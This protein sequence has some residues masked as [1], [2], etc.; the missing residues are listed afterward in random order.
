[1]HVVTP[2]C[3]AQIAYE[4]SR[5]E[6][7]NV[8]YQTAPDAEQ[9][10]DPPVP[11]WSR[12]RAAATTARSA[13]SRRPLSGGPSKLIE[14]LPG[15]ILELGLGNGRT[16]D[17]LRGLCPQR[18]IYVFERRVAA[19]PDCIPDAA[20]LFEGPLEVTLPQAVQ[21]FAATI[22]MVHADL[23]SGNPD[24]DRR[25]SAYLASQLP[26]LMRIGGIV[27]SDQPLPYT[28]A[29]ALP[30]PEGIETGRYHLFRAN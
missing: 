23:G 12:S 16:F 4:A 17:H 27:L 5:P 18:E 14:T 9:N 11:K 10:G 30:L 7:E 2:H 6:E 13:S 28:Q 25:T 15:P 1:M 19:H 3:G 20:H 8:L 21:Q 26:Q 22:P 24:L 29:L